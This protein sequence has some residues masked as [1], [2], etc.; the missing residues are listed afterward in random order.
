M[1]AAIEKRR[2]GA[3]VIWILAAFF[4]VFILWAYNAP[5][6]QIVRGPGVLVPS[7]SAQVVQSLEGGILE[8]INIREGDVVRKGQEIAKLNATRYRAEVRDFESQILTSEAKLLRLR[9]ELDRL[10]SFV[11]PKRFS[12]A[13]PDLASSEEQLFKARLLQF[14]SELTAANERHDLE[15]EKVTLME[16]MV[17]Q[18][19]L[20]AVELLNARTAANDARAARDNLL[21]TFALERSD[22]FSELVADLARLRAQVEQSRDQLARS[23]LY[24]PTDGIVNTIYTT[25]L[26]GV[27]QSGEPIFEITPLNDELLV[28]VRIRPEDI[29]FVNTSMPTTVKLTAYDYTVFGS[30]KGEISQVSADTLE[31]DQGPESTPYYKVLVT[32]IPD[33]LAE[34]SDAI[35]IR[36]GMLADAEVHVGERT[37]MQYLLKPL[38]K[39]KEAL[40]EP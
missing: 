17:A 18:Q 2:G 6:D 38:I 33:G 3:I 15:A 32:L 39:S 36:P 9:A 29:A 22:E 13:D 26:G 23:S 31:D 27:V 35:E 10:D 25:T 40:R 14:N 1:R 16:S 28:E 11:L 34:R 5:L 30:L 12:D 8:E 37:I 4:A 20:P 19:V 21:A 24:S 7:K